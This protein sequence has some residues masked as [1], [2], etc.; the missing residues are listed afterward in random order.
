MKQELIERMIASIQETRTIANA[1]A[2]CQ[3][4]E[5]DFQNPP[6]QCECCWHDVELDQLKQWIQKTEQQFSDQSVEEPDVYDSHTIREWFKDYTEDMKEHNLPQQ[7]L[8]VL[9]A[10]ALLPI[11]QGELS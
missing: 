5:G 3:C 1:E 7:A 10:Y 4:F 6:E 9:F 8:A 11:M 2:N